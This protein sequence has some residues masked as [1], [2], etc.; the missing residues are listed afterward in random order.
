MTIYSDSTYDGWCDEVDSGEIGEYMVGATQRHDLAGSMTPGAPYSA[1]HDI[2]SHRFESW[3][4]RQ[5]DLEASDP[6]ELLDRDVS[7]VRHRRAG[8]DPRDEAALLTA[9]E[10]GLPPDFVRGVARGSV[11]SGAPQG[12][13]GDPRRL[14]ARVVSRYQAYLKRL[15]C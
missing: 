5:V 9:K 6:Y 1:G 11:L 8:A 4:E 13:R 14:S 7:P 15:T 3:A 10:L 2:R 12:V